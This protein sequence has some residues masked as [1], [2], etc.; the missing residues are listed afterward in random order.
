MITNQ[1]SKLSRNIGDSREQT[2]CYPCSSLVLLST[3]SGE[4]INLIS[5]LKNTKSVG[6]DGIP[7]KIFKIVTDEMLPV[8]AYLI[9]L[10]FYSGVYPDKLKMA[11]VSL[12]G[13]RDLYL[14]SVTLA[15]YLKE[16][17]TTELPFFLRHTGYFQNTKT[18]LERVGLRQELYIRL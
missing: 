17:F 9:S 6:L 11:N 8:L 1:V 5:S 16:L 13:I 2:G 7:V 18:A 14:Y 3:D 4:V 15:R 12:W 10:T